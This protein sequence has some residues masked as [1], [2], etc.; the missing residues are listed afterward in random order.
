MV[1]IYDIAEKAGVSGSTVSRA[2]NGSR[3]VS[4]DVRERIQTIAR[5]LGF[6]KRNVRRHR[7]RTILNIRLVLPHHDSPER[8]LFFDLSQ[9]IDGLRK[10]FEPTAINIMCDLGGSGFVPFP[11]KKGGD[12]DAF[13]FA[14]HLPTKQVLQ[15]LLER[16]IPFVILNRSTPGLPC[17]TCDH[18]GGM[19]D[20]VSLVSKNPIKPCLVTIEG[21]G[22]VGEQR[23]E[24]LTQSL[25]KKKIPF[26]Q[27]D[28]I[29]FPNTA[30]IPSEAVRTL[31]KK[32]DTLFCINDIVASVVLSELNRLGIRVP[33]QC[34]VTGFDDSPL[35]RI[36]RPL[37]TTVSMPVFELAR[38]AGERLAKEVIEGATN[39]PLERLRGSL[40]I[41]E[42]TR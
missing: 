9:L 24:G 42:S 19:S 26:E 28:I 34:Q 7:Q 5:E 27:E 38:R 22:E 31:S 18:S 8:G 16:G 6:E 2:L 11:H 13:V 36:T 20:L 15:T 32:Y 4:D 37:L 1:T 23:L 29:T 30:S 21:F 14:F 39:I 25:A 3:L 40:L 17:I 10:G 12:T 33:E 41:G 35:R